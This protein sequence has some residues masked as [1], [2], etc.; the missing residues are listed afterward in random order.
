MSETIDGFVE[1]SASS[2]TVSAMV[3]R[4]RHVNTEESTQAAE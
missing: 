2:H 3:E 1:D 4:G